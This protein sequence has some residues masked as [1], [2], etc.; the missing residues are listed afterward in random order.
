RSSRASADADILHR[1]QEQVRSRLVRELATQACDHGVDRDFALR[2]RLQG[3][4]HLTA[5]ALT[6]AGE[7][8]D[9]VDRR[10]TPY[11]TDEIGELGAH[12]LEGN[13]LVGLDRP[14]QLA[15]VLPREEPL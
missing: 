5:V 14:T 8:D 3:D 6:A 1:L 7:T 13:A 2:D 12:R 15:G 4:E 10:I 9:R 11:H